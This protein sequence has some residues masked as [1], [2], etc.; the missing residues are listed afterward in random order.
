MVDHPY[1][2]P[3]SDFLNASSD[4]LAFIDPLHGSHN[5]IKPSLGQ[6]LYF[7]HIRRMP[8]H[9][10]VQDEALLT[11]PLLF[12][13]HKDP[14]IVWFDGVTQRRST[15]LWSQ[16]ELDRSLIRSRVT[17]L[18]FGPC[19]NGRVASHDPIAGSW[20]DLFV[21]YALTELSCLLERCSGRT[22]QFL[23]G[24]TEP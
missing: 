4:H 9:I 15:T 14:G 2:L 11:K 24:G 21:K 22:P 18:D 3:D 13:F 1:S 19:L 6:I 23:S 12:F 16:L 5:K 8:Y 10:F 7:F 17:D 20:L